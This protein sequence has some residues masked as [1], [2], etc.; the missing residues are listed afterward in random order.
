[1]S[2]QGGRSHRPLYSASATF[3]HLHH[4]KSLPPISTSFE[5]ISM[6]SLL[7]IVFGIILV[8]IGVLTEQL[9]ITYMGFGEMIMIIIGFIYLITC[10]N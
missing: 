10:R 9:Y 5:T 1:M 2:V 8:V 6:I 7:G 4:Q 3:H